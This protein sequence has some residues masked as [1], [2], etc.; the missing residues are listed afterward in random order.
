MRK[1]KPAAFAIGIPVAILGWALFR[2]ELLFINNTVNEKLPVAGQQVQTIAEGEFVSY[3]HETKG[4]AAFVQGEGK[5]FLKLSDFHTS[6]GP[7]VHVY[8]VKGA[9]ASDNGVNKNGFIDLGI[10]KGNIGD[11]FYE[12]PSDASTDDY[13]GVAIWCKRFGVNFGGASLASSKPTKSVFRY[14]PP[15]SS[16]SWQTASFLE[17][18]RVTGGK[19]SNGGKAELIEDAGKRWLQIQGLKL[20]FGRKVQVLLLKSEA[21]T[22]MDVQKAPKVDLGLAKTGTVRF[23]VDKSLD[24]WLYR[25]VVLWDSTA[26]KS[27]SIAW[28]RSDQEK[29]TVP[30]A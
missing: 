6:N 23:N 18:I 29:K 2:P 21:P 25:S 13:M 1:L 9:D 16:R 10:I 22:S 30:S 28:L 12:L 5:T 8:L 3:A 27:L 19:F 26:G 11:Q 14:A 4:N 17:Q 15:S 24:L 20:P 7:D